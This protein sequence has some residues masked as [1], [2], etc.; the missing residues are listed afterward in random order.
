ML[1]Q[2]VQKA[3]M[4]H[5]NFI[6][7]SEMNPNSTNANRYPACRIANGI[8]SQ[9]FM[10]ATSS[11]DMTPTK[12]Q[13][14]SA[15]TASGLTQTEAA[16]MVYLSSFTRWSEYERGERNMDAARYELFLIKT[17]QHPDY[18]LRKRKRAS[19]KTAESSFRQEDDTCDVRRTN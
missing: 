1:T 13:V 14:I 5:N 18:E 6:C 8:Q 11:R 4:Q 3:I 17:G 19:P 15:R 2:S 12:E 9:G 7:E 16:E 10:M